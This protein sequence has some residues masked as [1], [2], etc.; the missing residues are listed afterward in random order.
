MIMI[1]AAIMVR[2]LLGVIAMACTGYVAVRWLTSS[3]PFTTWT[4]VTLFGFAM[5]C[6]VTVA[7]WL[8]WRRE[9]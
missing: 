5:G 8:D 1:R 6:A 3:T 7:A 2:M 4:W 9:Y